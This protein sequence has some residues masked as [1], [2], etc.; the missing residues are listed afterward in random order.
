[1]DVLKIQLL[2]CQYG[3][4]VTQIAKATSLA[5]T[6]ISAVIA[7][8]GWEQGERQSAGVSTALTPMV[9]E[10]VDPH[11]QAIQVLKANE[12]KKQELLAPLI[13]ITEMSILA[14]IA[15]AVEEL[16][17]AEDPSASVQL[18]NLVKAF[19]QLTQDSVTTKVVDDASDKPGIA[20]QV[21]TQIA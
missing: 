14:K 8:H 3:W 11:G 15:Q 13:A 6:Y 1:M 2:Y 20:I 5:E 21:V 12:V 17:A 19:K 7:E 18:T 4:P 10:E 9:S 16:N